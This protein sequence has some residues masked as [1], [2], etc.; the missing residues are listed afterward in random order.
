MGISKCSY[1]GRERSAPNVPEGKISHGI[2]PECSV[3]EFGTSKKELEEARAIEKLEGLDYGDW[4]I[5]TTNEGSTEGGN[6]E[7]KRK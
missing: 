6:T 7:G 2:C 1:C 3:A 4:Y 5:P